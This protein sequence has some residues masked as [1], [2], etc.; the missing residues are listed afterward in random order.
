MPYTL[1]VHVNDGEPFLGEIDEMPEP[2]AQFLVLNNPRS[3]DG[4]ELRYL[5]DEVTQIIVPWWRINYIE[6]MPSEESEGV[7]DIF[8]DS[9]L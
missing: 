9:T 4:K 3:R 2:T 6:V 5:L 1:Y 7:F 8:G